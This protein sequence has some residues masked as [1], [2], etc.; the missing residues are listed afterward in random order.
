MKNEENFEQKLQI[1]LQESIQYLLDN[2]PAF[3]FYKDLD[4]RFVWANKALLESMGKPLEKIIGKRVEEVYGK[5]E[6]ELIEISDKY[7]TND[8]DVIETKLPKRGIIEQYKTPDGLKW[9]KTDKIPFLNDKGEVVGI[10]GFSVDITEFKSTCLQLSEIIDSIPDLIFIV[11][12]NLKFIKYLS[13]NQKDLFALPETFIGKKITEV[14][15]PEVSAR[16]LECFKKVNANPLEPVTFQYAL[17]V[18]GVSKNFEA[19]MKRLNSN[20]FIIIVR[21]ITERVKIQILEDFKQSV[22][23]LIESNQILKKSEEEDNE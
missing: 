4:N 7:F 11:D 10:F 5:K 17:A 15:P 18:H 9:A 12:K 16:A 2:I 22:E 19:R 6:K 8:K 14:L 1:Q 21:D 13:H 3:A 20:K 23:K